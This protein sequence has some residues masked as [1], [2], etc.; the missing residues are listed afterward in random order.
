MAGKIPQS[1]I[2]ELLARTDVVE[3]IDGFVPLKKAGKDYQACCPFHDE[4]T[5]SFTVSQ[6]KQFYHCFGCGANGTAISF[7]ME[8]KHLEFLDAIEELANRAGIPVPRE[9]GQPQSDNRSAE[10]YEL[11]EM[12]VRFYGHQLR[13]HPQADRVVEYL[14]NRGISGEV[15]RDFELGYAPPGW[16]NLIQELGSSEAGQE[17]LSK[18]GM[19]IQREGGGF[20]DRFRDRV[21]FPIRDPRG[22]V[23]GFGGRVMNDDTPKYLNSPETPIFSKG[24]ELYGLYQARQNNR[25]LERLYVVEGYM[26][27]IALA[28]FGIKNA[29]ATLGTAA[30]PEHLEKMFR[31]TSQVVFCFDGDNAGRKAAWRAME[32]ALSLVRDGREAFF[33][34]MPEGEDPDSFV[35]K[36]GREKFEDSKNY[37]ALSDYLFDT[38][39]SKANLSTTQG[40]AH[41]LEEVMPYLS[42][43]PEG[44]LRKLM[45]R[46]LAGLT[47]SETDYVESLL[48]APGERKERSSRPLLRKKQAGNENLISKVI[49]M[50][51][52]QPDLA[53]R[54]DDPAK[55]Q[56]VPVAG[57]DFLIELLDLVHKNPQISCAAILEHWRDSRYEARLKELAAANSEIFSVSTN[58][59][60]EFDDALGRLEQKSESQKLQDMA[61]TRPSDLSEEQKQALRNLASSGQKK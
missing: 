18:N 4:K 44:A 33:M 38:L 13:E 17:R 55:M 60:A 56:Q 58:L 23:I 1:F 40:Q 19:V 26:D 48:Q 54:L 22:R 37:S 47:G 25:E 32:T 14:K 6:P 50:L 46:D 30:T 34:F 31:A 36:M 28:Q 10:L 16:D 11:M 61:R 42:R 9:A 24:R 5:P 59:E 39:K 53:L 12:V 57:V 49:S 15:A 7:L 21:M 52:Y 20:Y 2:D 41:F 3:L 27:V 51:L 29:V 8:Y 45:A 43:M 35:R